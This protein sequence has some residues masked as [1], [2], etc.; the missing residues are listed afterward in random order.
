VIKIVEGL[1]AS[2]K[3]LK[4]LAVAVSFQP[5]ENV[6]SEFYRVKDALLD[7]KR[8]RGGACAALEIEYQAEESIWIE[9]EQ[10]LLAKLQTDQL[11]RSVFEAIGNVELCLITQTGSSIKRIGFELG[12]NE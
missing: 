10:F 4:G 3:A 12:R 9:I 6:Q 5:G 1:A 7:W 11:I 8:L 2:N